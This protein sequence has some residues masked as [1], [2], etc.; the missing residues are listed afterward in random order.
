MNVCRSKQE[1]HSDRETHSAHISLYHCYIKDQRGLL[2][3]C[4]K[5]IS[6][7][8]R[9][10][11]P[12]RCVRDVCFPP[13]TETSLFWPLSFF[14]V[15]VAH[16]WEKETFGKKIHTRK[17]RTKVQ[18]RRSSPSTLQLAE[19]KGGEGWRVEDKRW[20]DGNN[21]KYIERIGEDE[22]EGKEL[23][24]REDS[25]SSTDMK[26]RKVL[27]NEQKHEKEH[28]SVWGN[29]RIDEGCEVMKRCE[30]LQKEN[31]RLEREKNKR[32]FPSNINCV[33]STLNHHRRQRL[34]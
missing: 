4:R 22:D 3:F 33:T 21:S 25:A 34:G 23:R 11:R 28:K 20:G 12:C 14:V 17:K 1:H 29:M 13:R 27:W 18:T 31:K 24:P 26:G 15:V 16:L 9:R 32:P 8:I 10:R 19:T 2:R 6:R 7:E 5:V 30:S